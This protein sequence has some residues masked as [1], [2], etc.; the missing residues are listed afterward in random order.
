MAYSQCVTFFWPI[1]MGNDKNDGELNNL[2]YSDEIFIYCFYMLWLK[3]SYKK[4]LSG[5]NR[6]AT[7]H[8]QSIHSEH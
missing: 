8:L 7:Y 2:Y 5:T 1:V 4:Q 6:T 3:L